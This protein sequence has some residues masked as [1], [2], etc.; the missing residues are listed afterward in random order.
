MVRWCLIICGKWNIQTFYIFEAPL[1]ERLKGEEMNKL[2][3]L[4]QLVKFCEQNQLTSFDS[5]KTGYKLAVQVPG[6]FE[7]EPL[8]MET[9]LL[10][11][12]L[13]VC[14]TEL[15]RNHSYISEENMKKAMPSLKYRP[16][17]AHIHQLDNGE[18][19]FHA[20]DMEITEDENGEEQI[21]YIESQVGAFTADEPQLVY[22]KDMQKTYV[23]AYG[24][25]PEEYTKTADIIRRK[26]GTKVSCEL[27]IDTFQ[28]NAKEKYLEILDFYFSGCT[29]LGSEKDGT[30]IGE[31]MLGA[32][33]DI[34]DFSEQK[35]SVVKFARRDLQNELIG[36][37]ERLNTTL[38]SININQGSIQG[39]IT[40][41][42]E[43]VNQ[44]GSENNTQEP[45]IVV[46]NGEEPESTEPETVENG[47][48]PETQDGPES[49]S[50]PD[51][52]P[53]K[54][55]RIF[56][57]LHDDIRVALYNL[58]APYEE[59][60]NT[61]YWLTAVYDTH[62][63][64]EN[65]DGDV[66]W[67]QSYT[68]DGDNVALEG[69]RYKLHRELLTD[70][71][72][73][74]LEQMRSTY[75]AIVEELNHYKATEENA[76]KAE[77]IADEAYAVIKETDIYKQVAEGYKDMSLSDVQSKLDDALLTY[78]KHGGKFAAD[79]G[80]F[81]TASKVTGKAVGKH[82]LGSNK[83]AKKDRYGGIFAGK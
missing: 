80:G 45:E 68:K 2:L 42:G 11:V 53:G 21:E 69:E 72:Y 65:W 5:K 29:L 25:I 40:V 14:H 16:I 63:A 20:H 79:G 36:T 24:A 22:D 4:N 48:E 8:N 27:T 58:I 3:T 49:G 38:S 51:S 6:T 60:D 71:E 54:Y 78:A 9:G 26:N 41:N 70:S 67:G 28:Y 46:T 34:A 64:F 75:A 33:L 18:Y 1:S 15:N 12:K 47:E 81:G 35:N 31:G 74:E 32:R 17:L 57:L 43:G 52:E 10:F 55:Q 76:K 83:P 13:K 23:E 59:M 44:V 73:A 77:L 56:E 37:L 30:E 19:D 50:E 7:E 39:C 66:I 82:V 61:A 62:F